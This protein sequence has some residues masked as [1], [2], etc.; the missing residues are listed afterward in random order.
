ML[1]DIR[2]VVKDKNKIPGLQTD[3]VTSSKRRIFARCQELVGRKQSFQVRD[4]TG[5]V[6]TA[7]EIHDM[8]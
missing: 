5:H 3:L 6:L 1:Y 4:Q 7:D 8:R 2:A